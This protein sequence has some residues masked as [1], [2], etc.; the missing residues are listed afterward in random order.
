MLRRNWY[1]HRLCVTV[2]LFQSGV[3]KRW[4]EGRGGAGGGREALSGEGR[5][6]KPMGSLRDGAPLKRW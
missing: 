6:V 5:R 2:A 1:S 4:T 3:K